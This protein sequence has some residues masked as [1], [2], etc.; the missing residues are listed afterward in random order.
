MPFNRKDHHNWGEIRPRFK[1]ISTLKKDEILSR[2]DTFV[3]QDDS[4]DGKRVTDQ[5]YLDIPIQERHFWSP[6]LRI[7]L[8]EDPLYPQKVIVRVMVGPRTNVWLSFVLSYA[9]LGLVSLFG[10][11]YGL[12]QWDLGNDTNWIWCLP[13]TALL[14]LCVYVFA[15]TGQKAARDETLHLVSVLYHAIGHNNAERIE[16]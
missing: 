2:I 9:L 8:D 1:L 13:I 11:M 3:R 6:E 7:S 12:V 4:V 16:S 14:T 5:Y 10:G 15:K